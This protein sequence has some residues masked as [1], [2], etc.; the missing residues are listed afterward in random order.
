MNPLPTASLLIDNGLNL[1][2]VLDLDGLP[3]DVT[4]GIRAVRPD[5]SRFRQLILIGH[6]GPRLW[7]AL[8]A[9]P[10]AAADEPM[11]SFSLD[12]LRRYITGACP[13]NSFAILYPG[14]E[15][16]VPLQRLGELAGWHHASPFRIGIHR[17]WGSWFAYRAVVLADT[18]F[19]PTPPPVTDSPCNSCR[20]RPCAAA[21][22][23]PPLD[24]TDASLAL[25]LD[26]RLTEGS[27]C[28]EQCPARLAC[29]V[30]S[31]YRYSTE[32]I[33]YHYGRSLQTLKACRRQG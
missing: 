20:Q 11:D 25:C 22:P 6:A 27:R 4:A 29:P 31:E 1:Q 2:A 19:P 32:Q 33:R 14:A 24:D 18:D 21:C 3:G 10:F 9:S 28:R 13:G 7:Q 30:G 16:S 8:Q 23:V 17:E 26:Y 12:L 15:R 5:I